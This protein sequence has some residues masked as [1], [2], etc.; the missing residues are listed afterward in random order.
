MKY[1]LMIL[2][3]EGWMYYK[4]NQETANEAYHEFLRKCDEIELNLDNVRIFE[5]VL[6][7]TDDNNDFEER[8]KFKV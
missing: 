8:I 6:R 3:D 1:E 7:S 4:T 5:V 2:L